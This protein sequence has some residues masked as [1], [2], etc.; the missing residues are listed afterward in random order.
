[1]LFMGK[2]L[3]IFQLQLAG[4]ECVCLWHLKRRRLVIDKGCWIYPLLYKE[5]HEMA[6]MIM[7]IY[8]CI[9]I[10]IYIYM[11][12]L[13]PLFVDAES[14]CSPVEVPFLDD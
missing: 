12:W 5:S 13:L 11:P 8:I 4:A 9:C 1:M 10:Y 3:V 2:L 14:P 7:H 6:W